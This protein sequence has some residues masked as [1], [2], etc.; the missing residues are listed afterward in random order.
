MRISETYGPHVRGFIL[1]IPV[2][3]TPAALIPIAHTIGLEFSVAWLGGIDSVA[4]LDVGNASACPPALF[5]TGAPKDV[6]SRVS[7]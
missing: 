3:V 2:V 7:A 1:T 4:F 6:Q 5:K